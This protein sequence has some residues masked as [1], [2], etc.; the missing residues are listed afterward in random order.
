MLIDNIVQKYEERGGVNKISWEFKIFAN[1][2]CIFAYIRAYAQKGKKEIR[3]KSGSTMVEMHS[4][5]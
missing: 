2:Y 5:Q 4:L 1:Y 3:S